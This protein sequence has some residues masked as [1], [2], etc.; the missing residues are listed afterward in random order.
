MDAFYLRNQALYERLVGQLDASAPVPHFSR[1]TATTPAVPVAKVNLR[2]HPNM[3]VAARIRPML[4]DEIAE[5]FPCAAYPRAKQPAGSQ[6]LDLHDLYNHP[7]GRPQLKV[8]HHSI[9]SL[10]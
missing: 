7:K 3:T 4:Q 6:I 2:E 9:E 5:G 10:S 8:C 1:Q